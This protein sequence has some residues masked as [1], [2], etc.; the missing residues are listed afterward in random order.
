MKKLIDKNQKQKVITHHM[1]PMEPRL[2]LNADALSLVGLSGAEQQDNNNQL[3]DI[4]SDLNLLSF[5]E[6]ETPLQQTMNTDSPIL[7]H[8]LDEQVELSLNSDIDNENTLSTLQIEQQASFVEMV[9]IDVNT[10]DYEQLLNN[11]NEDQSRNLMIFMIDNEQDGIEQITNILSYHQNVSAIHMISH[12][13]EGNIFLGNTTLNNNTLIQYQDD[14]SSWQQS[15]TEQADILIYGCNVAGSAAGISLTDS[16]GILTGADI[17]ASDDI[18]GNPEQHADWEL[19][20][21]FGFVQTA[22]V[23]NQFNAANWDDTL[24]PVKLGFEFDLNL[25]PLDKQENVDIAIHSDGSFVAVWQS[26]DQDGDG[27]GIFMRLYDANSF[28]KTGDILVNVN[29]TGNQINP[30]I[31]MNDNGEYV[32]TWESEGDIFARAYN[33]DGSPKDFNSASEM[34][35]GNSPDLQKNADVAIDNFGRFVVV[36]EGRHADLGD[37]EGIF[38]QRYDETGQ[39]VGTT[40]LVNNTYTANKQELAQIAMTGDGEFI[41]VFEDES[42]NANSRISANIFDWNQDDSLISTGN[43]VVSEDIYDANHPDVAINTEGNFVI[44]WSENNADSNKTGI[45]FKRYD[46]GGSAL[47]SSP[48]LVN[49]TE[50]DDQMAPS[51]AMND[52]GHFFITWTSKDS[53]GINEQI[54]AQAFFWDGSKSGTEQVVNVMDQ[55]NQKESTVAISNAGQIIVAWEGASLLDN[56][57]VHAQ[58]Y[59]WA[60]GVNGQTLTITDFSDPVEATAEDTEVEISF[61]ELIHVANIGGNNSIESFMVKAISTGTLKIGTSASTA[62]AWALGTNDTINSTLK[63]YWTP[64]ANQNGVLSAFKVAARDNGMNESLSTAEVTVDVQA[65]ND[66]PTGLPRVTG[67]PKQNQMLTAHTSD[68]SDSDGLGAFSYQWLRNGDMIEGATNS[69]YVLKDADVGT[70]ISVQITY[71]DQQ[72]TTEGPLTSNTTLPISNVND[73]P[74]GSVSISNMTPSE[75]SVLTATNTIQDND[76]IS[77]EITY[78]WQRD[79]VD[80]AGATSSTYT[81]SSL[82][83]NKSI[84][85][86]ASYTDNHGTTESVFSDNTALVSDSNHSPEGKITINNMTPAQGDVLTATN[87]LTDQDGFNGAI[88]YQWQRNGVNITGANEASYT[89]TQ[90]DVG[91]YLHVVASYTDNIGN[92]ESIIS[93][94]TAAVINVNDLPTG[95]PTVSGIAQE[96][97][98]LIADT[99]NIDDPDGLN[100]FHYQWLRNGIAIEGATRSTYTLDDIDVGKH[101]SVQVSFTDQHGTLEGPIVSEATE[102]VSNVNDTPVGAPNITGIP[103]EDQVL[104]ARTTNLSDQD[105]IVAIHY[106]WL[107]DG[108]EI[109]GATNETYTLDDD[110]V[111]KKI[112]VKVWYTDQ[113]GEEEGPIYSKETLTISNLNDAPE[114]MAN[115]FEINKGTITVIKSNMLSGSD[116]DNSHSGLSFIISN[117][118]GG[119]FERVNNEGIAITTFTQQDIIEQNIIFRDDGDFSLPSFTIS[120]SDGNLID[121]A[122]ANIKFYTPTEAIN[123]Q[124]VQAPVI[125]NE[126][127]IETESETITEKTVESSPAE[128]EVQEAPEIEAETEAFSEEDIEKESEEENIVRNLG[129]SS[130]EDGFNVAP[131]FANNINTLISE[132]TTA[133]LMQAFSKDSVNN[134]KIAQVTFNLDTPFGQGILTATEIVSQIAEYVGLS[135][136]L[137]TLFSNTDMLKDFDKVR[138]DFNQSDTLETKHTASSIAVSTGFSVGYVIWLIRSGAL[139]STV[140]SSLPAWQFIDPL[141]VLGT[142]GAKVPGN[143]GD[144]YD[145]ADNVETMFEDDQNNKPQSDKDSAK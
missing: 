81:T 28:P 82:D 93:A 35:I 107:R 114:L 108:N 33:A 47:D 51:V 132:N 5:H 2:L 86:V 71:T 127:I 70:R 131:D 142:L 134:T 139:L 58:R 17:A 112:Q 91:K 80:I 85:V 95:V 122:N 88:S 106:Q 138:E 10:P 136:E 87:N 83:V 115:N 11:L 135:S 15:L 12:G 66:D 75:G 23:L 32:I 117:I 118:A 45:L 25:N 30:Q 18:T 140:L 59:L 6:I 40:I 34:T 128:L 49:T 16:L 60:E 77:G 3:E 94:E 48:V 98:T 7:F 44:T 14:I 9:F 72:G 64:T 19:E 119:Q 76:G 103:Q 53:N 144:T 54:N 126:P 21:H 46:A 109:P 90:E 129:E 39:A 101:I 57:G 137:D 27:F 55:N 110:D 63:A 97:Q 62:T 13:D 26:K 37:D 84:R 36:W 4:S 65:V 1:A 20:Y 124:P 43:F 42:G 125:E 68:I 105:G 38:I 111:G 145:D 73:M 92:V 67:I 143:D 61:N 78:Q 89:L 52:A 8:P 69:T 29:E 104:S 102:L 22:T 100:T 120:L 96:N 130:L 79:G 99:T 41:V 31:A 141:P 133:N 50:N 74:T 121:T 24:G 123:D 113:H 56:E 116:I